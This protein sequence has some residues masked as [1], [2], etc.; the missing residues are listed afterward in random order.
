VSPSHDDAGV[1]INQDAWF[2]LGNFDQGTKVSY[3]IKKKGNGVYVF[4]LEG[5]IT[6]NGETLN[7]RDGIGVWDTEKIDVANNSAT[8]LLIMDVPMEF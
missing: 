4:V 5:S 8:Q 7:K 2:N 6:V 3:K 1:W